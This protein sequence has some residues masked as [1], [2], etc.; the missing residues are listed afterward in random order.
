VYIYAGLAK[1][2]TTW[3]MKALPLKIWLPAQDKLPLIGWIFKYDWIPH[4]FSWSGMLY[5]TFIILFLL[6]PK[7]RFLAYLTVIFFHAMTGILFQIG[8]FPV[9]MIGMT[10]IFFSNEFHLKLLN[11]LG[12]N[13]SFLSEPLH[14]EN[15]FLRYFIIL[16]FAF[17]FIF[18]VRH[19]FYPG[20]MF[21]T[22]QGYRFGWR[23]MLMEKAGSATFYVKDNKTG[24]EG[25][26]FNAEFLSAHQEKQ[27]A[28]Q[29]D[30]ILQ[31]AHFLKKYYISKGMYD[32]SIRAEVY[33]TLNGQ[34]SK[35]LIDPNIDLT[36]LKDT[37]S[38]KEWIINR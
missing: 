34:P 27:M 6:I 30:M 20:S 21:W 19:V 10:I 13:Y 14:Y 1:I 2:N 38:D 31:Y 24:R 23:V 12:R 9:V 7:T 16:F 32:P 8:V 11:Y 33:V 17:Q 22:E 5:D 36:K 4:L 29:P 3:L 25:E 35:L 18:P 15:K 37:W 28:M 26:V